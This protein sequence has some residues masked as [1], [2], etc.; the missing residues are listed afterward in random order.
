MHRTWE[1]V[2]KFCSEHDQEIL[3]GLYTALAVGTFSLGY[4][5]GNKG[6]QVSRLRAWNYGGFY[7]LGRYISKK[8]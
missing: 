5:H 1:K 7:R 3:W 6:I 8:R 4:K 2:K